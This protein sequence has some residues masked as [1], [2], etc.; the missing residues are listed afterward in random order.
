MIDFV[1]A[2]ILIIGP[3]NKFESPVRRIISFFS[4]SAMVRIGLLSFDQL[5]MNSVFL[6]NAS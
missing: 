5:G 1:Y 3:L 2:G 6:S 4:I